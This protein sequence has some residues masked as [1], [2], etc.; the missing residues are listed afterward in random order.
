M[1]I[2]ITDNNYE[3]SVCS[4]SRSNVKLECCVL[5]GLLCHSCSY[6]ASFL[7]ALLPSFD[8][9]PFP[10]W[11]FYR[12]LLRWRPWILG[13]LDFLY[14][15]CTSFCLSVIQSFAPPPSSRLSEGVRA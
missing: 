5:E 8:C 2:N 9:A 15:H 13:S 1:C 7:S 4:L 11:T 14:H 6:L 12:R 10:C 3:C